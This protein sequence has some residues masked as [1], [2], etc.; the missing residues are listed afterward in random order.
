M[1]LSPYNVQLASFFCIDEII[2][3]RF[4]PFPKLSVRQKNADAEYK[5][6]CLAG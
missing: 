2:L 3:T 1:C 4:F 5:R 6:N